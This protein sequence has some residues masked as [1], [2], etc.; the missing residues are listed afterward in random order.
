MTR[1]IVTDLLVA[2]RTGPDRTATQLAEHIG[3]S[4]HGVMGWLTYLEKR[5]M[6]R[7]SALQM[8]V[9]CGA[10]GKWGYRWRMTTDEELTAHQAKRTYEGKVS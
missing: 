3:S 1:R 5:G 6:V 10:D 8:L 2:L 9:G 4:Y 7:R